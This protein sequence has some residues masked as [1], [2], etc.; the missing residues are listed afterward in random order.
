MLV[1]VVVLDLV[2]I[3]GYGCG[4]DGG[5]LIFFF[6]F[7]SWA[8]VATWRLLLVEWWRWLCLVERFSWWIYF[9]LF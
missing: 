4:C 2:V 6:F 3:V 7:L 5:G 8:M 9:F 1:V